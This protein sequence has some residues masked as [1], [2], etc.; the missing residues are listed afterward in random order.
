[1]KKCAA[2][3]RRAPALA[4]TLAFRLRAPRLEK[5]GSF[6]LALAMALS[7]P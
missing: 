7:S 4:A 2:G 5:F 6:T 1:M 3:H